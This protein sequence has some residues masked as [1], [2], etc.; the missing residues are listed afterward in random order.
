MPLRPEP[1][2]AP[3]FPDKPLIPLAPEFPDCPEIPDKLGKLVGLTQLL[4]PDNEEV[5]TYPL[6]P[7]TP[8]SGSAFCKLRKSY[9]P[10]SA[11][12]GGTF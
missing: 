10:G 2:L 1:P 12:V 3:E 5:N 8:K 4:K 11:L 6:P 7:G 9:L